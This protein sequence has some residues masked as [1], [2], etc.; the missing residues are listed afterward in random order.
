M[1]LMWMCKKPVNLVPE[2]CILL[3][4]Y[5]AIWLLLIGTVFAVQAQTD[6]LIGGVQLDSGSSAEGYIL[7]S[8]TGLTGTYLIDKQGQVINA[9]DSEF[10]PS[11][12]MY[13]LDNGHLLRAGRSGRGD[14]AVR[15]LEEFDW[16]GNR[17]WEYVF[18]APNLIQHHDIQP[19]PDG[20][21]LVLAWEH[22]PIDDAINLGFDVDSLDSIPI[23][24]TEEPLDEIRLDSIFEINRQTDGVVWEWHTRDHLIQDTSPD[25]PNYGSI[26][27]FPGRVNLNYH[28][29]PD[30]SDVT[31]MNSIAYNADSDLIIVSVRSF[32]EIWIIDHSLTTEE[33]SGDAGDLLYRWGNPEA[34]GQGTSDDRI[35]YF[36]HDARWLD[37]TQ[38]DSHLTVF[39]NGSRTYE[40][41]QS[42]VIEF[43]LPNDWM[44]ENSFNPVEIVWQSGGDFFANNMSGGQHLPNSNTLMTLA[45]NGRFV[46]I[47]SDNHVVWD[48]I[49]PIYRKTED[50]SSNRVFRATFY[51]ADFVG[52]EGK[53][54]QPQGELI[55]SLR[56]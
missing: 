21:I 14:N 2:F 26:K 22:I 50:G 39:N 42:H 8:P 49:N 28:D 12:A 48:Y 40:I 38:A 24:D 55:V 31:H 52:F 36:Q 13:L 9:W 3:N 54:L 16:E 35:L 20:N 27:D 1:V 41:E 33:A 17:V 37:D 19:M 32:S 43:K 47:T 46:E 18:D 15:V 10:S 5:L 56:R 7:F 25:Y 44:T 30:A 45:P 51:P 6:D 4:R 53:N 23:I 11:S 29:V 34:Y